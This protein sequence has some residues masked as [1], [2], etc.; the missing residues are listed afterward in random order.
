MAVQAD[1]TLPGRR[2]VHYSKY[3]YDNNVMGF[4]RAGPAAGGMTVLGIQARPGHTAACGVP[5]GA[6]R[7]EM[8]RRY[9]FFLRCLTGHLCNSRP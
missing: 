8:A 7:S 6:R 9:G 3:L 4:R 1:R 2:A 5:G